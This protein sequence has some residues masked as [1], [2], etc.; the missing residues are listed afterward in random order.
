MRSHSIFCASVIV[1]ALGCM[2]GLAADLTPQPVD[3]VDVTA[4]ADGYRA[5]KIV[6]A[7]VAN[8]SNQN[9]GK[10]DDLLVGRNDQVLYAI[11]SV[12]GFLGVGGKLVAVPYRSLKIATDKLVLPGAS[13]DALKGLPEFKYARG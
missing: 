6:G 4:L 9:I 8:D 2:S 3:R 5:S 10:I 1:G 11:I 7:T 13:R 12:G